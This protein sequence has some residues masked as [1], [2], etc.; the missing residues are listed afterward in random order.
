MPYGGRFLGSMPARVCARVESARPPAPVP[1]PAPR[2]AASA[3]TARRRRKREARACWRSASGSSRRQLPVRYG[4]RAGTPNNAAGGCGGLVLHPCNRLPASVYVGM[5][6]ALNRGTYG[7]AATSS[8]RVGYLTTI[9]LLA[10]AGGTPF[11]PHPCCVDLHRACLSPL[12]RL[13]LVVVVC[14]H[15]AMMNGRYGPQQA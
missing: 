3:W 15:R 10:T 1:L 14:V 7:N 12:Q 5:Y 11:F 8:S 6:Y 4:L 9:W 2:P 13:D